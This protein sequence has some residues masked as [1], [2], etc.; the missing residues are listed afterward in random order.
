MDLGLIIA[1]FIHVLSGVL[2]V[3]AVFFMIVFLG[4]AVNQA[5]PEGG[6]VMGFLA[7]GKFMVF[8]PLVAFSSV[9]SGLYLYWRASSGFN[10]AYMGSRVGMTFGTGGAAAILALIVGVAVVRPATEKMME[11]GQRMANTS[12][13]ERASIGAELAKYRSRSATSGNIVVILLLIAATA[14]SIARYMD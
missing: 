10:S 12:E 4:P 1:R 5:G 3:G 14:M 8:T 7:R 11:L 2:W 6:K 9:L 13:S